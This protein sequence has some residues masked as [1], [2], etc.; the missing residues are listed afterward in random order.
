MIVFFVQKYIYFSAKNVILKL[1]REKSVTHGNSRNDVILR[2]NYEI[3]GVKTIFEYNKK[4]RKKSFLFIFVTCICFF[5]YFILFV[6]I[7]QF[8]FHLKKFY[9]YFF[10]HFFSFFVSFFSYR[11]HFIIIVLFVLYIFLQFSFL[12]D[13]YFLNIF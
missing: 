3:K 12:V 10:C 2:K 7:F 11:F 6:M 8:F 5:T 9:F 1:L 4:F 13:F